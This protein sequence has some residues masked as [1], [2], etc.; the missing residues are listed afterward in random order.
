MMGDAV[1]HTRKRVLTVP[2]AITELEYWTDNSNPDLALV[3]KLYNPTK[4]RHETWQRPNTTHEWVLWEGMPAKLIAE[5][6]IGPTQFVPAILGLTLENAWSTNG[7]P[8]P[9]AGN[10]TSLNEIGGGLGLVGL[11]AGADDWVSFHSGGNYP[12]T[13]GK[14][15]HM[16]TT[17]YY[18]DTAGLFA[19]HGLVG[20]SGLETGDNLAWTAPNDGIWVE[21]D[22]DV[23][24]QLHFVTSVG[25]SRTQTPLGNPPSDHRSF[26]IVVNDAYNEA[27]LLIRGQVAARHST[28]LPAVDTQLKPLFMVGSRAGAAVTKT[29]HMHDLRLIFD[30]G[31][32]PT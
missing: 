8:A 30:K 28:N 21:Y 5:D 3:K 9:V 11:G 27:V 24:A 18:E 32:N 13:I 17:I 14:S 6:F 2:E 19:F 20:S 12:V 7:D 22:T 23:D 10:F 31:L 29:L 1:R 16:K 4:R 25:G 15:P 26:R